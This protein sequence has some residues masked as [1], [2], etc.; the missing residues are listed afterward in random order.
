VVLNY[1]TPSDKDAFLDWPAKHAFDP[2]THKEC[3][4]CKGHGGWNLKISAYKLHGEDTAINR[5]L[6]SHFKGTCSHCNGWGSIPHEE[7][8]V[9]HVWEREESLGNCLHKHKCKKLWE[10]MDC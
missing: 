5:H 9:E 1:L 3:H 10:R 8:C 7:M 2:K 4:I 6:Y